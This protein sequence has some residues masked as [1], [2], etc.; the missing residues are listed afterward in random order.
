MNNLSRFFFLRLNNRKNTHGFTLIELLVVIFIIGILSAI[1]LV[2]FLSLVAKA[3]EVEPRTK[4]N[5]GNKNQ[6]TYYTENNEFTEYLEIL[7]LPSETEN[8]QYQILNIPPDLSLI[9]ATPKDKTMK[10]F[11]GVVY[12]ENDGTFHQR[13]CKAYKQDFLLDILPK[14]EDE[15]LDQSEMNELDSEYCGSK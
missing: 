4:I 3:K 2:A 10:D 7:E 1:G 14:I 12:I 9:I 15:Q 13:V 8:Y 5:A 6:S 11:L